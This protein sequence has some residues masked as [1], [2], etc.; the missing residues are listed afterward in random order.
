MI[1]IN[2]YLEIEK[3]GVKIPYSEGFKTIRTEMGLSQKEFGEFLGI[4]WRNISAY[5]Q[6]KRSPGILTLGFI[7]RRLEAKSD[8]GTVGKI[9]R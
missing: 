7:K 9:N 5:E 2:E 6:E 4:P 3:D 8:T 1:R